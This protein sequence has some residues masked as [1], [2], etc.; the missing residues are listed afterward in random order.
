ML[1]EGG[2]SVAVKYNVFK[3]KSFPLRKEASAWTKKM[4]EEYKAGGIDLKIETNYLPD[5]KLWQGVILIKSEE[6]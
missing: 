2:G 1:M 4:K 6:S 3:K 5:E